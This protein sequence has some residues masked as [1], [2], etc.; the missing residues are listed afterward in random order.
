M[1]RYSRSKSAHTASPRLRAGKA[2]KRC[3]LKRIKCDAMLRMPCENCV[4]AGEQECVLRPTKKGTY[5]RKSQ[6]GDSHRGQLEEGT[7]GGALEGDV[8]GTPAPAPKSIDPIDTATLPSPTHTASIHPVSR[9][10][11]SPPRP[12]SNGSSYRDISWSAMFEYFFNSRRNGRESMDKCSITYL[13]ETFPLA[14]VLD[15]LEEA[16]RLKL[17]HP[18][19]PFP[20]HDASTPKIDQCTPSHMSKEDLGY[21]NIQRIFDLPDKSQ[22]DALVAVFLNRVYPAYPIV[23]RQERM[24]QHAAGEIPLILLYSICFI[25]ATFCH[26]SLLHQAGY[27]SRREARSRFRKKAK[28]LFD[29]GFEIDKIVILQS[30][31]YMTFWGEGPNNY[32][33]FYSWLSTAVTIA[34]A[35]GIHRPTAT[36]NMHPQ[37]QSLLRRLWWILV[38]RDTSC[39]VPVCATSECAYAHYQIQI[40][41]LSLIVRDIVNSRFAPGGQRVPP[42]LSHQRLRYWRESILAVLQWSENSTTDSRG[43]EPF[44]M[45]L[46]AQYYDKVLLLYLGQGLDRKQASHHRED[47]ADIEETTDAVAQ[48][49]SDVACAMVTR[50]LTLL[51]P[52]EFFHGI[53]LAQATFYMK[54][55]SP[56]RL[57]AQLGR[58]AL[59]N[60]QM[61]LHESLDFWGPSPWIMQLFDGL[62]SRLAEGPQRRAQEATESEH[63]EVDING[64]ALTTNY[65]PEAGVFNGLLGY[66]PWQSNPML[67]SLFDMPFDMPFDMLLPR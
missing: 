42:E 24:A 23:N 56:Q 37:D 67:S 8:L 19:P 39:K 60:C 44:T 16:G 66:E 21:L 28:V 50:S 63:P 36:T 2:C 7:G 46:M 58:S 48:Q 51:V 11:D 35:M 4:Q 62:S 41:R 17:H 40:A 38:V 32:W 18:G 22:L 31:I 26:L 14:I 45:T 3:N 52:H 57:V 43:T 47:R 12:T 27:D 10:Q 55:R 65:T 30:A 13:G 33:N 5:V 53:F 6:S 15:D 34:E 64:M 29:S 20:G 54:L 59:N 1:G 61:V 49:I 9:S 25:A